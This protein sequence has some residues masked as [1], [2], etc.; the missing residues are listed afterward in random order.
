M[1]LDLGLEKAG[2]KARV[3]IEINK[4]AVA[5]IKANRNQKSD[6]SV[7]RRISGVYNTEKRKIET[8]GAF[9]M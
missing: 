6:N 4:N 3:A 9:F 8:Q 1:G 5:T 2:F 7:Y